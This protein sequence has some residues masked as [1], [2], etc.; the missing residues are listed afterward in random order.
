MPKQTTIIHSTN[1]SEA[2]ADIFN[3][4]MTSPKAEAGPIVLELEA[5]NGVVIESSSIRK[6]VDEELKKHERFAIDTTSFLIFPW[7]LWNMLGQPELVRFSEIYLR[8]IYPSLKLRGPKHNSHGTYF[9]R[10]IQFTGLNE[11]AKKRTEKDVNQ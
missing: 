2:W 11:T 3:L 7:K 4:V 9:Q 6:L 1:A 8:K 5:T 10:M